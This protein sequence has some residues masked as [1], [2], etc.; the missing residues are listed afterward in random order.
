[1][2]T[3][4]EPPDDVPGV[5]TAVGVAIVILSLVVSTVVTWLCFVGGTLPIL[6]VTIEGSV[7]LGMV[8]L[9]VIDPLIMLVGLWVAAVVVR[10]AALVGRWGPLRR[11]TDRRR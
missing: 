1:M 8:A 7:G 6:G 10:A 4:G 9:V 5:V 11:V 3:P 2:T